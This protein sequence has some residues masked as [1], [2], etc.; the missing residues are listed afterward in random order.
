MS[1]STA[2]STTPS[3]TKPANVVTPDQAKAKKAKPK[4]GK[5]Q[6]WPFRI[7]SQTKSSVKYLRDMN[8][9]TSI[10]AAVNKYQ[11]ISD[12]LDNPRD[13]DFHA[14]AL[15]HFGECDMFS[16][17]FE[18]HIA[19]STSPYFSGDASLSVLESSFHKSVRHICKYGC[20]LR[21]YA[22]I[23]DFC[24]LWRDLSFAT[25]RPAGSDYNID[26]TE[27]VNQEVTELTRDQVLNG[28][29]C[30]L[31]SQTQSV[32]PHE[33]RAKKNSPTKKKE[34]PPSICAT[35]FVSP[36]GEEFA[37]RAQ[38][39]KHLNL[40]YA[41][42]PETF[43]H[44]KPP[45]TTA[46][47][48]NDFVTSINPLYSPLGLLEEL[49]IDD[50]WKMLVSTILL[51][52]TQRPQV[53]CILH[54]FLHKWPDA[55]STA[56]A[57]ADDIFEIIGTLGLGNKRSQ[58]LIRFSREYLE[59]V[60]TKHASSIN[61]SEEP[62]PVEFTFNEKEVKSLHQCGVY[63]WSAYQLFILRE[64]PEEET[65]TVCDHALQL[66]VEHKLGVRVHRKLR[67]SNGK[68][69]KKKR[70]RKSKKARHDDK[71]ENDRKLSTRKSK[72]KKL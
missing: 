25:N 4:K 19:K 55:A 70:K 8:S 64:L 35:T 38:V 58:S 13:S 17:E 51:N 15:S 28:W 41:D 9:P 7:T 14:V 62:V 3:K 59:L 68:E 20:F 32:P 72:R 49:F 43:E 71:T 22:P 50:P 16:T 10:Y 53:D 69:K 60:G 1:S 65:F 37:T 40:L 21:A 45:S 44:V 54:Q 2:A 34:K 67:E 18:N 5:T 57:D 24:F 26:G 12:A 47:P 33:H 52:K 23:R 31:I 66:Y 61:K 39:E 11:S 46:N 36:T 42:S 56:L 6:A 29:L 48:L 27:Q 63:A 30:Q